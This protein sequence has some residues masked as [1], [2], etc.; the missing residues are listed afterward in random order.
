MDRRIQ[1]A[2]T[3]CDNSDAEHWFQ[4]KPTG[5]RRSFFSAVLTLARVF[6]YRGSIWPSMIY[7]VLLNTFHYFD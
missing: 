7:F 1:E 6:E 2:P 5:Q 4:K 3:R